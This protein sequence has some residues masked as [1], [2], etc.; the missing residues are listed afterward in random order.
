MAHRFAETI[1][2]RG[3]RLA[4]SGAH[5]LECRAQAVFAERL[6]QVVERAEFERGDRVLRVRRRE[7]DERLMLHAAQ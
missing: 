4:D 7:H 1:E 5:A 2:R 3:P 6:E